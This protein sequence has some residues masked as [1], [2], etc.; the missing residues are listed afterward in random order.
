MSSPDISMTSHT[1]PSNVSDTISNDARNLPGISI[2]ISSRDEIAPLRHCL[3]TF[4]GTWPDACAEVIVVHVGSRAELADL[5]R[6]FPLVGWVCAEAAT[7]DADLRRIGFE[8]SNR[9]IVLF[10]DCRETERWPS[11]AALCQ[12]W[13]SWSEAG[14]RVISAPVCTSEVPIR[15]PYLSVV[16]PVRNGG[17]RFMMAL[18]ALALTDLPRH[19]WELV[20]VDDGSTDESA[21]VA[22]Q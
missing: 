4:A 9:D 18:Q 8:R 13:R 11:V 22:A 21:S 17:P 15:Y 5:A 7:M 1:S 10:L 16:V 2:V 3:E 14:G 19:L 20:I 6:R 12:N